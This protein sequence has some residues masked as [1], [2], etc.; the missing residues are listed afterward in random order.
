M[1]R[2]YIHEL[3][4]VV[5][6]ERARYQH[7]M[8]ANW[9]PFASEDRRQRLFG[10]W[11]LVGSTGR[12]P[13]VVN[14]WEYDSWGDLAHNFDVELS[15]PGHRD[16]VLAEWWAA[17]AAFRTGGLD[18]IVVAHEASPGIEEWCRSGGPGSVG[19]LHET[20]RCHAG[21]ADAVADAVVGPVLED[22]LRDGLRL[23]GA[24]R[25]ALAADDE[26]LAIW[27]FP[28][29]ASWAAHQA[30]TAGSG[31]ERLERCAGGRVTDRSAV[32]LV[33]AELSPLRT[34]RQPR[35]EDRRSLDEV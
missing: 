6:T 2:V 8:T 21:E 17:A 27:G 20:I 25:T 18:R 32:L 11:T 5:G 19:Y 22:R 3:V 26:V 16:P 24:Y 9:V 28:D 29:W 10:I 1:E 15:H 14:L 35:V 4:D 34:G 12:W 23:V 7:H 33:D 13:V 30:S 31:F